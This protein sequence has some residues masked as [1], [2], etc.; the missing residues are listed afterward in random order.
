MLLNHLEFFLRMSVLRFGATESAVCSNALFR[1][2]SV[3]SVE[4]FEFSDCILFD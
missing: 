3:C 4:R 1:E 2:L